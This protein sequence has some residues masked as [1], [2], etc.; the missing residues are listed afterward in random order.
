MGPNQSYKFLHSKE[1]IKKKN[2]KTTPKMEENI[3]KLCNWQ[4][5]SLQNL[6]T[7][8]AVQY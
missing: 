2:E 8:Q 6:Q 4:E 5:I 1:T 7:A 3:F